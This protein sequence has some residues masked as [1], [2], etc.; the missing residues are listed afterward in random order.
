M[1]SIPG[2]FGPYARINKELTMGNDYPKEFVR[3]VA[4]KKE[5]DIRPLIAMFL[6]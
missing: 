2:T 6:N 1:F 3:N 4:E 5:V